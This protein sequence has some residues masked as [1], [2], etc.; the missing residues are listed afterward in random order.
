[1][2]EHKI[3]VSPAYHSDFYKCQGAE[4]RIQPLLD[5]GWE[6]EK[7]TCTGKSQGD[8]TV[9]ACLVREISKVPRCEGCGNTEGVTS[10]VYGKKFCKDCMEK[11]QK[12]MKILAN[13]EYDKLK[14]DTPYQ[15]HIKEDE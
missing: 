4:E 1:M 6:I 15:F 9:V 2:K 10:N 8:T 5:E 11:Y 13:G 7:L 3:I 14:I 12:V